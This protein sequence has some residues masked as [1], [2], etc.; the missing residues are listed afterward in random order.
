[1]TDRSDRKGL[2]WLRWLKGLIWLNIFQVQPLQRLNIVERSLRTVDDLQD[3][4]SGE[5]LKEQLKISK[6]C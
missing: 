6:S 1:M 5:D 4:K 3:P 2:K